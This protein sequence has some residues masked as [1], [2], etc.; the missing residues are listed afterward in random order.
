MEIAEMFAAHCRAYAS[1]SR[2]F[3]ASSRNYLAMAARE[4]DGRKRAA[5]IRR[6]I[7]NQRKAARCADEFRRLRDR[8]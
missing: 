5:H 3:A 1:L 7:S 8:I 2:S 4:K 6:A